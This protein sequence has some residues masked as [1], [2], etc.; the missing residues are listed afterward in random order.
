MLKK[1][2]QS[3][4]ITTLNS[5]DINDEFYEKTGDSMN[6]VEDEEVININTPTKG[7]D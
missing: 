2:K 5:N 6:I 7:K 1:K 4:Q 3:A